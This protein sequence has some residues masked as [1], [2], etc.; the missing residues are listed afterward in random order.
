MQLAIE[1]DPFHLF[2]WDPI[3]LEDTP[4]AINRVV[5]I[6][7]IASIAC[8]AFFW[9]G[10]NRVKREKRSKVG[11]I[12]ESGYFFVRNQIAI[13]VIGPKDGL[14]Y[15]PYLA[16]LLFFIFFMNLMEIVPLINFPVTSRMAIPA[17]L[18]L[19]TYVIFNVVGIKKQG[20]FRYLKDTLF[21]PDVPIGVNFLLALIELFSVFLIRPLTLAIRLFANMMAGHVLLTIF[22]LFTHEFLVT[23]FPSPASPLGLVTFV[24]ACGLILFELMVISI[25]AYIFT[26]LTAFYISESIHGHGEHEGHEE[27]GEGPPGEKQADQPRAEQY[28]TELDDR[29]STTAA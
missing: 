24:V 29:L 21:P 1:L 25:Q 8:M 2:L 28:E 17:F 23:N 6:M 9:I 26:M 11:A 4:F 15:A 12:V 14:R 22:F 7:F 3:W 19:V 27:H 13:D 10:S 5:L 20:G 16:A 18:A